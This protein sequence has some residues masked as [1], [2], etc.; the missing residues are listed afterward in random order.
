VP[1]SD[2][3]A[4]HEAKLYS[5]FS[6]LYDPLFSWFFVPRQRFA[7]RLLSLKPGSRILDVGA[8]SGTSLRMYPHMTEVTAV[9]LSESMLTM[10]RERVDHWGL[11][12]VQLA[13]MDA[14]RL[15]FRDETFDVVFSA[16]VA[17][18]VPN[19]VTYFEEL[20]RVCRPGG[21]LCVLNH[22]HYERGPLAKAEQLLAPVVERLGW[23]SDLTL[24]EI[25]EGVEPG[26]VSVH[27]LVPYDAW[28]VVLC[29]RPA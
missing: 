18:V 7:I 24:Q 29:R 10:A 3:P 25:I 23:R 11:H 27:R 4:P 9:D 17:S 14:C 1:V 8:G 2:A 19:R 15:G 22:V 6:R 5:T 13:Q 21:L 28:P 26:E 16:F 20:K 12:H